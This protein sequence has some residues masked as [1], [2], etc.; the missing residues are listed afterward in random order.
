MIQ[1]DFDVAK[2]LQMTEELQCILLA[3][4][5]DLFL[6][7]NQ[8]SSK[9]EQTEILAEIKITLHL[10]SLKLG[11]S[12]E[13]LNQKAISKIKLQLLKEDRA[14][15]KTALLETLNIIGYE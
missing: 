13:S 3:R 6:A 4:V 5:S 1:K 2:S 14:E 8:K 15:W 11:V 10:L 12:N 7:M 9:V